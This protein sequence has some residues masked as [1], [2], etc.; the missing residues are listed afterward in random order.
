MDEAMDWDKGMTLEFLGD[1][2]SVSELA[3]DKID[4]PTVY[5]VGDSTS[6][7]QKT[8]P[9]NSWGQTITRFFKPEVAVAFSG[10]FSVNC[11]L[12]YCWLAMAG[13]IIVCV[14]GGPA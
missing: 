10:G 6:C 1:H 3:I 2:P 4:V 14:S 9:F 7:D 11:E 8:E 5:V 13:K 12:E